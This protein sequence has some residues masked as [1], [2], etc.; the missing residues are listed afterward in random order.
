MGRFI[1]RLQRPLKTSVPGPKTV[2]AFD[3]LYTQLPLWAQH[4]AVTTYGLYWRWLRFGNGYE[5]YLRDYQ[6]REKYSS[7]DWDLWQ[8]TSLT[9]L[10]QRSV[11]TV[12]YYRETWSKNEIKA[13]NEGRLEDLPLLDK[14]PIRN[15]PTSFCRDDVKPWPKLTFH[16]SGS[17]GTPIAS[18][19]TIQEVRNSLALREA[20]SAHWAG[21]SFSL[22]RAT[23]SGR[24]VEP[25]PE[26]R[27]PFYRFNLAERQ[28]YLSAFHL[29]P[30]TAH[31][32]VEALRKH[33]VKW[34]TGYAVSFYLL[35]KFILEQGLTAPRLQAII[36]TS[37][38]LTPEMRK[39]MESAFG[40]RVYEE[41]STVENAV[42]ASECERGQLHIS[43]DAGVIEILRPDG[44][45][46]EPGETGE[47]VA[48]CLAR[49]YQPFIRYRLGD[50]AQLDDRLCDCGRAMP[51]LREVVGRLEDVLVGPDGRQ[52][53]RFHG[54]FV[55]QRHVQEAQIIQE[56]LRSIRVKVVPTNGFG[57]N[58]RHE[59]V[60][61]VRQRL[62]PH[63][64]VIVERVD[65]IP[66]TP[67][68][69]FQA[70]VSLVQHRGRVQV[71]PE[72]QHVTR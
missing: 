36:T 18:I 58:D 17:T 25:N 29:A 8:R 44:S 56:T 49:D 6:E 45:Q 23:F 3:S 27:G 69:K 42:F 68:G 39:V 13:A 15:E 50:L 10:L 9:N 16:T 7:Q 48:T 66:R 33:D 67:A 26:S 63:V 46:C 24:L 12:P 62:G 34:A 64:Q 20:R 2:A 65:S 38:K 11:K 70:V 55:N 54:V 61:R 35:A 60:N 21:V 59:I 5:H 19:W 51:V 71:E 22:P 47:V 37:E 41:Y 28:V 31:L 53:V 52:M 14:L 32:Y 57:Q 1:Q 40:C 4:G 43:P 72:R 30:D